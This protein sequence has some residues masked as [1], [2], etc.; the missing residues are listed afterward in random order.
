M[1][2]KCYIGNSLMWVYC[3]GEEIALDLLKFN[4]F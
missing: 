3:V 2:F 4:S 1:L